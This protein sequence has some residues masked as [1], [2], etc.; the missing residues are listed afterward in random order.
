MDTMDG[1]DGMDRVD[2]G[3]RRPGLWYIVPM[4]R[5]I[6][7]IALVSLPFLLLAGCNRAQAAQGPRA[8][9]AA[10]LLGQIRSG[11]APLI[12]DV[13]TP[14]EFATGHVPGAVNIPYDQMP[15]R[16]AEIAAHKDG[17]VVLYCRTGRRSGIAA[18]VLSER[19]FK[20][21][22]LL[23]GDMPGWIRAGH[24]VER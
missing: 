7:V 12:V 14:G 13:R 8:V 10:E 6:R 21:L 20:D 24:P 11:E 19:G 9:E 16:V 18:E 15:A 2:N 22:G 23:R 4:L 5:I 3:V 17:P 1:M